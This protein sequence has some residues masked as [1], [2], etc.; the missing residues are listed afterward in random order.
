MV[1]YNYDYTKTMMMK[2]CLAVPDRNG[3]S[4]VINTFADAFEI[5][6][7]V[8]AI[9]CGISKIIYL[10]GWQYNGHDDKYPDFFEVNEALKY[11]D[12]TARE[13][14]L[15][16]IEEA[17]KYHT[18]VSLHINFNDAYENAPS[19][20]RFVKANA[21]IRDKKGRPY[22]IEKYNGL[23]CYKTSFKEYWESG[24]FKEM[25]DRLFTVVPLSELKTVHVDNFQC[26]KNHAPYI[27]VTEM[28][29]YR[30]RMIEY[31][32]SKGID[33]TS[34]FTYR[35]YDKM[36]NR[37]PFKMRGSLHSVN[38]P[39]DTLGY[40]P[41]VWWYS[42]I[43]KKDLIT[44]SPQKMCGGMYSNKRFGNYLY[45]NI[46]GEDVFPNNNGKNSDWENE[47]KEQFAT[48]QVPFQYLCNFKRLS[49]KGFGK[50]ERCV[51][52]NEVTSYNKDRRITV[53]GETVKENE[54][55]LLPL[56][57]LKET[58]IAYSKN[59]DAREWI[60]TDKNYKKAQI[61]VYENGEYKFISEQSVTD[62]K[63]H[64]KIKPQE[65]LC[66][67]FFE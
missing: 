41:A 5:I 12:K 8:D 61:S 30:R 28:Q 58:Y 35:E 36:V 22:G 6:K 33:I 19:F 55:L 50:S 29:N 7:K 15:Y 14:L 24:L 63:I 66:I 44:V 10:V 21:L 39:I 37:P 26:Y 62:G 54:N 25:F 67:R 2:L 43:T 31:V 38:A 65:L 9:T 16:L 11:P 60:L 59:G 3:G 51:F 56:L 57:H 46:H 20:D 17:K 49:I 1:K 23:D 4:T 52:E 42:N 45:G 40:I 34:E 27:S 18:V 32:A 48:V 47:F 64:L 13:S 53:N